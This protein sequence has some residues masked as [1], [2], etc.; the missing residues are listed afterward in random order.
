M[1]DNQQIFSRKILFKVNNEDVD[2]MQPLTVRITNF[3]K[4]RNI[5]NVFVT[6]DGYILFCGEK[7]I[8]LNSGMK[9]LQAA[10]QTM[11]APTRVKDVNPLPKRFLQQY[12]LNGYDE[13]KVLT[14]FGRVFEDGIIRATVNGYIEQQKKNDRHRASL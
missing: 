7:G 12:F 11:H 1:S 8:K 10:L 14:K 3:A 6:K 5:N 13:G 9:T 2:Q 4:S